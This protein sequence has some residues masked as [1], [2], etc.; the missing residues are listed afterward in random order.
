[1]FVRYKC[2]IALPV[3][4]INY[5]R[6]FNNKGKVIKDIWYGKKDNFMNSY[7]TIY[8]KNNK[9]ISEI[10]STEYSLGTKNYYYEKENITIISENR[11]CESFSCI[12]KNYKNGKLRTLKR[13][14]PN[15]NLYKYTFVYNKNNKLSYRIFTDP[16]SEEETEDIHSCK[17]KEATSKI[18]KD[19]VNFYDKKNRLIKQQEYELDKDI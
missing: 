16:S 9:I 15:G 5:E 3:D 6:T 13:F 7:R 18:Y 17:L 4:Y 2:T 11:A 8:D 12:F 14:Y 19:I 1:M 10:D